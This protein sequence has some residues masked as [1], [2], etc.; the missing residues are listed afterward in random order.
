MELIRGLHNLRPRHR[1][2][3]VTVGAFDGVHRGHQ[4][5]IEHLTAKGRE[6]DLPS[7]VIVF[8]PL[9]REYFAPLEA[10][11]RLMSFREKFVALRSLG[12]DRLLRVRFDE[13]VRSMSAK[14]FV[15]D[16]FVAGLGARYVVLGDDFRFGN[17]R[18]GDLEFTRK[19]GEVHGFEAMPTSTLALDGERVSSTRIRQALEAGDFALAESLLGRPYSIAGKVIYGRQ[20]GREMGVPTANVALN[21]LRS[22]LSGVFAVE[23]SGPGLERAPGIAN[24]GTRPTVDEGIR[25]ILEVHMLDRDADLYGRHIDVTFLHKIREEKKFDSLDDLKE[26]ITRDVDNT[27]AWFAGRGH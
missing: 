5:V 6:L 23:V 26:A 27:R 3:V 22:P 10:P 9:P 21:R 14:A 19:L 11:P 17:E 20:L 12:V 4:A 8:E 13:R 15:E 25:A 7:A 1:G 2:C 16:V 24:V 18:E